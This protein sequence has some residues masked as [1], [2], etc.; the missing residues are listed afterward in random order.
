MVCDRVAILVQGK[1]VM[2]GTLDELTTESRRYEITIEGPAPAWATG[3]E[4]LRVQAGKDDRT[5]LI[6]RGTEPATAQPI[7]DRL[8]QEQRTI[9]SVKPV[10]ETLEDLFMRAVTDPATGRVLAPGAVSNEA[11][12]GAKP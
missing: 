9:V 3:D 11:P 6:S 2:Q 7:I 4:A 5:T 12:A 8:R 1:V 10:R